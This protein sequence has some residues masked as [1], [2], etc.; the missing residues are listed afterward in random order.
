M[1]GYSW[2][3][4]AVVAVSVV[5]I[6]LSLRRYNRRSGESWWLL[7]MVAGVGA[8]AM[9]VASWAQVAV[10]D[11]WARRGVELTPLRLAVL[12]AVVE[13]SAKFMIVLALVAGARRRFD[14]PVDGVI[15][16]SA[17]GLGAAGIEIVW[18]VGH[19]GGLPRLHEFVGFAGHAVM[20]GL[21]ALG[22]G[23]WNAPGRR[24]LL[25][26][27]FLPGGILLGM[28]LHAGWDWVSHRMHD[29]HQA[30]EP[31]PAHLRAW[32]IVVISL[33]TAG[34]LSAVGL[35]NA[36]SRRAGRRTPDEPPAR[37]VSA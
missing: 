23:M 15:Y 9:W 14:D 4:I 13:E 16:G 33:G 34:Y 35:T 36:L 1:N 6:A 22:L 19:G 17:A 20:G 25:L 27:F 5:L 11:L 21:T 37:T 12:P 7:L 2:S 30:G 8:A 18:N 31:V 32:A 28:A 26:L 29:H 10:V 3:L 24:W